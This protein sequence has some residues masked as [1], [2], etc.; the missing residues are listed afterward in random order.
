[1]GEDHR[2]RER[3]GLWLSFLFIFHPLL[4]SWADYPSAAASAVFFFKSFFFFFRGF[5]VFH[6]NVWSFLLLWW[7]LNNDLQLPHLQFVSVFGPTLVVFPFSSFSVSPASSYSVTSVSTGACGHRKITH[8]HTYTER[9]THTHTPTHTQ[10]KRQ[11]APWVR[12]RGEDCPLRR[13]VEEESVACRDDFEGFPWRFDSFRSASSICSWNVSEAP[14]SVCFST[15]LT[16][17]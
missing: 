13:N 15:L 10:T 9:E 6:G 4:F 17:S 2:S 1:V 3:G 5:F 8:A 16:V 7:F 14:S 11:T 12:T